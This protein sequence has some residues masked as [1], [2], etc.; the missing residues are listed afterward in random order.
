MPTGTRHTTDEI[1]KFYDAAS[2]HYAEDYS[3]GNSTVGHFF[4]ARQSIVLSILSK[5]SGGALLDVGCGPG[6]YTDPSIALGYRYHGL[7]ASPGMIHECVRR[8][9]QSDDKRFCIGRIERLPFEERYFDAILCLGVLE[10]VDD[11][12]LRNAV[13][14][15]RRALKPNGILIISLLNKSSPYW[16]WTIHLYP[17]L[18]FLYRNI[19]HVITNNQTVPVQHGIRTRFFTV[20]EATDLLRSMQFEI[21]SVR[22]FGYDLYPPPFDRWLFRILQRFTSSFERLHS[23]PGVS[24]LSKAFIICATRKDGS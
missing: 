23:T 24:R 6:I 10:Y 21:E 13:N 12:E 9:S 4:C 3:A 14:N 1:T 7:D 17:Y 22:Y 5:R 19:K 2:Q 16:W 15:L 20:R 8:H 18:Q 11:S